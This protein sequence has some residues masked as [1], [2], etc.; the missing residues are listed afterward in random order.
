MDDLD[1]PAPSACVRI[2][3]GILICE[4]C[5]DEAL[6]GAVKH[7]SSPRASPSTPVPLDVSFATS[8]SGMA[9]QNLLNNDERKLS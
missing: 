3:Y 4:N 7:C 1:C 6:H 5:H 8:A 9:T 2:A